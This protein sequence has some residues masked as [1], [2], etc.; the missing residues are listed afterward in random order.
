MDGRLS[1]VASAPS[2][3]HPDEH[4]DVGMDAIVVIC[5]EFREEKIIIL[6]TY[7]SDL[8]GAMKVDAQAYLQKTRLDKEL[9]ETIRTVY[10]RE[11]ERSRSSVCRRPRGV[12]IGLAP[13]SPATR[14]LV[15]GFPI[16]IEK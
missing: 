12:A 2:G 4:A 5:K 8:E 6:T 3:H 15:V 9:L 11:F 1:P 14:K 7:K 13:G 16:I 10:S